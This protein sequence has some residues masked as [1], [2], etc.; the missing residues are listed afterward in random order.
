MEASDIKRLKEL[1]YENRKL[2]AML[3]DLSLEHRVLK[4]IVNKK[5][6]KS[7]IRRELV[8]YA[9]ELHGASLRFACCVVDISDSVYR[10]QPDRTRD[11]KVIA[12]LMGA[13]ERYPAYGFSKL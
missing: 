4:G 13:V 1:E 2:K 11:D 5:A 7:A 8:N 12:K 10:Y 3:S 9:R 6:V